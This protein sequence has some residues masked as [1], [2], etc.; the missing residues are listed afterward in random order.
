MFPTSP[1]GSDVD[2]VGH[3]R[4]LQIKHFEKFEFTKIDLITQ[5]ITVL[6]PHSD[7][8]QSISLNIYLSIY[9]YISLF[10]TCQVGVSRFYQSEVH[11]ASRRFLPSSTSAFSTVSSRSQ[12]ALPDLN[13]E[14]QIS[15]G[16]AGPQARA[17]SAG[18]VGPQ[19]RAPDVR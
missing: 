6:L 14:L 1:K 16:T 7:I 4:L 19:P 17:M 3:E 8:D 18:T 11:P 10:P 12:W 5:E 15:V 2:W 13:R 9:I